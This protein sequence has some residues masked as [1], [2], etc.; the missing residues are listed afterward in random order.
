[1]GETLDRFGDGAQV[2]AANAGQRDGHEGN[3][4]VTKPFLGFPS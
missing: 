1:M 2:P 4:M 3:T